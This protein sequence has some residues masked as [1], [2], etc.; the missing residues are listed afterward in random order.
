MVLQYV[1]GKYFSTTWWANRPSCSSIVWKQWSNVCRSTRRHRPEHTIL[2]PASAASV[3]RLKKV[4]FNSWPRQPYTTN[5]FLPP[6]PQNLVFLRSPQPLK[7]FCLKPKKKPKTTNNINNV[8][9]VC[10]CVLS[11]PCCLLTDVRFLTTTTTTLSNIASNHASILQRIVV[12]T[13]GIWR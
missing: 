7:I 4:A 10:L 12:S 11:H 2:A 5:T 6:T 1:C 13:R 3:H 8:Q 9:W